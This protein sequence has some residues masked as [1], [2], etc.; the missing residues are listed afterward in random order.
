MGV[1]GGASN[2]KGDCKSMKWDEFIMLTE[3]WGY[4]EIAS[5]GNSHTIKYGNDRPLTVTVDEHG[6]IIRSQYGNTIVYE[7]ENNND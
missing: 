3:L 5:N 2:T 1:V 7:K 4:K 6:E